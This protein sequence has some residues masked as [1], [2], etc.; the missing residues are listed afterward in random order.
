MHVNSETGCA[1]RPRALVSLRIYGGGNRGQESDM[2]PCRDWS[3][4]GRGPA[5]LVAVMNL[6]GCGLIKVNVRSASTDPSSATA[7]S[8]QSAQSSPG[9]PSSTGAP[10]AE[11][12]PPAAAVQGVL[13]KMQAES[14]TKDDALAKTLPTVE[15]VKKAI[16]GSDAADSALRQNAAFALLSD[17]AVEQ[18]NERN[19]SNT[20]S[21]ALGKPVDAYRAQLG[22]S[23]Q[24]SQQARRYYDDLG[25]R[26]QAMS[27]FLSPAAFA[28][29]QSTG[30]T[31]YMKR[32]ADTNADAKR[33]QAAFAPD[34]AAAQREHVD[35][36]VF[37]IK[38]GEFLDLPA[39]GSE[40]AQ[41]A[42]AC[43]T[44]NDAWDEL[45]SNLFVT[46]RLAAPAGMK[47]V[48]VTLGR[49]R[50][51]D[52]VSC[53]L[54]VT[55]L[56]DFA[57]AVDFQTTRSAKYRAEIEGKLNAK[58]HAAATDNGISTC[59]VSYQ[60]VEL[61]VSDRAPNRLWSLS[62]LHVSYSPFGNISNCQQGLV[63]VQSGVYLRALAH[64][65]QKQEAAEPKM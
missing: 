54:V 2:N 19:I 61:G 27:K 31:G 21:A 5:A 24:V 60:G 14:E 63:Q 15:Q 43:I 39:C 16:V 11:S 42:T 36:S 45:E 58:Y 55:T 52:W 44:Q 3:R 26:Q 4:W 53:S 22:R 28:Q 65:Q 29:W 1:F 51:P 38:L 35:L 41:A 56:D 40:Q 48:P 32:V 8:S 10:A 49:T 17:Y 50:C 34:L 7:Q 20:W 46:G 18:H 59:T 64:A 25:F 6:V 23:Q 30:S 33:M 62:A 47:N 37:G 57:V 9:S 12:D 13:A